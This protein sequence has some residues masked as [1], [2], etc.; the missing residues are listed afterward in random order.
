LYLQARLPG[1]GCP[2]GIAFC[3]IKSWI[4]G[5][6]LVSLPFADHTQPLLSEGGET[7][8]LPELVHTA[9]SKLGWKCVE[10]RPVSAGPEWSPAL[11]AG[12]SFW[13]HTLSLKPRTE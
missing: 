10:L 1:D 2:I 9:R 13:L 6:R 5:S 8:E 3:E 7:L 11:E 12:Q 4:T